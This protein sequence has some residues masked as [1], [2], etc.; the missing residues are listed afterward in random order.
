MLGRRGTDEPGIRA[1]RVLHLVTSNTRRGAEVAAEGLIRSLADEGI[2][3]ELHALMASDTEDPLD[4]PVLGTGTR[5]TRTIARVRRAAPDFDV[6]LA[7][8]SSTLLVTGLATIGIDVPFIYQVI[9][10]PDVWGDVPLARLRIGAPMRRAAAVVALWPGAARS[11]QRRYGIPTELTHVIGNGRDGIRFSPPSAPERAAAARSLAI[12]EPA[13]RTG[14]VLAWIGSLSEE[15]QPLIGIEI[16]ERIPNAKLLIAG[17]GPLRG[18]LTRRIARSPADV[19]LLGN[20]TDVRPLLHSADLLLLTSRTEGMPGVAVEA[21]LSGTRISAPSIGGL[22]DLLGADHPG[23]F[24]RTRGGR[25]EEIQDATAAVLRALD[26][27]PR[28]PA[29]P[30]TTAETTARWASLLRHVADGTR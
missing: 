4:I 2:G 25:A 9:G 8:G 6:V 18:E 21:L 11:V 20:L 7:H 15:K 10:D 19:R 5:S 3:G 12:A 30:V 27:P 28:P 24:P 23:L 16:A 14:P 26:A 22:P 1:L 17:D 13:H 29:L